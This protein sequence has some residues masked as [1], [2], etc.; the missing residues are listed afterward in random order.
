MAYGFQDI[1]SS[2]SPRSA[3]R[4]LALRVSHIDSVSTLSPTECS[5]SQTPMLQV[6]DRTWEL[7]KL[8]STNISNRI[9][10]VGVAGLFQ[11]VSSP[12]G[13]KTL[14]SS[15]RDPTPQPPYTNKRVIS[16]G[17]THGKTRSTA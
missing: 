6:R 2:L 7:L 9:V 12:K 5:S 14:F 13:G 1:F 15:E 3:N 4:F 17:L 11:T 16:T 10:P 8:R